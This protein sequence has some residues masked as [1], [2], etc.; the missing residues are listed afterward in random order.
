[1]EQELKNALKLINEKCKQPNYHLTMKSKTLSQ[2][3]ES[4]K[5]QFLHYVDNETIWY[6]HGVRIKKDPNDRFRKHPD[7][8]LVELSERERKKSIEALHWLLQD[9]KHCIAHLEN[10]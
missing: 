5:G 2:R 8:K 6:S 9:V 7:Y 3:I 1:M 4:L 10:K